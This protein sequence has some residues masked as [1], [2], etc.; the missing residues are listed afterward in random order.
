M[1][2]KT[3]SADSATLIYNVDPKDQLR[4][5]V[6]SRR[7]YY[8]IPV[9]TG[10]INRNYRRSRRDF[11][12]SCSPPSTCV[13]SCWHS[14]EAFTNVMAKH[15]ADTFV[16]FSWVRT[17]SPNALLTVSPLFHYN[18]ANYTGNPNDFPTDTTDDRTSIYAGGQVTLSGTV[19]RNTMS[20]GYYGFWQHDNQLFGVVF[21]DVADLARCSTPGNDPAISRI[22]SS[23]TGACRRFGLKI[24]SRRPRGSR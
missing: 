12:H 16:N 6:S 22:E 11:H 24:N 18:S 21:C 4:L 3:A 23:S 15:E 19:A 5:V 17:L 14:Q 2:R 13:D 8:Q 20:A 7:D 9:S 10:V 1:T